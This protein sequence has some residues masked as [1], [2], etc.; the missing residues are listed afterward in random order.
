MDVVLS[1]AASA[2]YR[3]LAAELKGY[4]TVTARTIREEFLDR[5]GKVSVTQQEIVVRVRRFSRAP[6]W[7]DTRVVQGRP[8]A[9]WLGSRKLR[10]EMTGDLKLCAG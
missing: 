7:L 3:W 4:E 5:P 6:V 10:V 2:A 9:P 1:V 8:S